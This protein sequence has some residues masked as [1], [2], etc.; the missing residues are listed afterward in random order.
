MSRVDPEPVLTD[1]EEL[2]ELLEQVME[3]DEKGMAFYEDIKEKADSMVGW[4]STNN[5]ATDNHQRA[6][7]NWK[8]MIEEKLER[9]S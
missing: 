2:F 8:E 5:V 9:L 7:E 4:I 6:V 3:L 1:F